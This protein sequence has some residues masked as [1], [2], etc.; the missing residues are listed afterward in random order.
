MT[1]VAGL[2]LAAGAL[3]GGPS[4]T[5]ALEQARTIELV[6]ANPPKVA[7]IDIEHRSRAAGRLCARGPICLGDSFIATDIPLKDARTKR[8]VGRADALETVFAARGS[9]GRSPPGSRTGACRP[10]ASVATL[11]A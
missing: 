11:G 6:L 2:G 10:T 7:H 1:A 9:T 3:L 8:R 4:P 5:S